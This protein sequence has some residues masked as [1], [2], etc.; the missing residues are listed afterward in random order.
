MTVHA[1][2][3]GEA[4]GH[5]VPLLFEVADDRDLPVEARGEDG[6]MAWRLRARHRVR[7]TEIPVSRAADADIAAVI[8]ACRSA[9]DR[10]RSLRPSPPAAGASAVKTPRWSSRLMRKTRG[11]H[12]PATAP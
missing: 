6:R 5:L 12:G 7:E 9:R 10:R 11:R 3:V 1:V 8:A 2:A 4:A